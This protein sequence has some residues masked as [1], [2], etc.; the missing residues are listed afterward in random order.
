MPV[1]QV[2][3]FGHFVPGIEEWKKEKGCPDRKAFFTYVGDRVE[4]DTNTLVHTYNLYIYSP[5]LEMECYITAE[6]R[7]GGRAMDAKHSWVLPV[8]FALVDHSHV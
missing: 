2:Y 7:P 8:S 3:N 1:P 6:S 5:E 4:A